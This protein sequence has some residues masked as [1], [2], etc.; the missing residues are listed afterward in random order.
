MKVIFLDHQGVMRI[1]KNPEPG[2]LCDFDTECVKVLNSI[3][4]TDNDIQIVVSSDWKCWV[5]LEDMRIFY[6]KQGIIKIPLDYT[7]TNK[8]QN[9]Y[10]Y[11]RSTEIKDWLSNNIVSH[12]VAIDDLDMK[13]YLSNFVWITDSN[14]GLKTNNIKEKILLHLM[15]NFKE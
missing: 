11:T 4:E 7:P 8:R 9:K 3:L 2:I 5:N 10:E 12:W 1:T 13:N 15:D 14:K 6:A